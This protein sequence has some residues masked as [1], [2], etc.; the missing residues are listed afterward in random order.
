MTFANTKWNF[1]AT[2]INILVLD[3]RASNTYLV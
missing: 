2:A 3:D 1:N